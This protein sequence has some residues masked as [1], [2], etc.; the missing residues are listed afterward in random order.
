MKL[1]EN[2]KI[3]I[4]TYVIIS[5]IL[6]FNILQASIVNFDSDACFPI[7]LEFGV[8]V[9]SIVML[10]LLFGLKKK[11]IIRKLV[12]PAL[13]ASGIMCFIEPY[14]F[15]YQL[16]MTNENLETTCKAI[17][18]YKFEKGVLPKTLIDLKDI[19][20][21]RTGF[22]VF[23]NKYRYIRENDEKYKILYEVKFGYTCEV[24]DG[25]TFFAN[26]KYT[27]VACGSLG[28]RIFSE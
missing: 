20:R 25:S 15:D 13:L 23:N 12:L 17:E 8:L 21:D 2:N 7:T 19:E 11:A 6:L 10:I 1:N 16:K 14:I 28:K 27:C 5:G 3:Q 24:W 26:M 22:K 18:S 4:I 9:I